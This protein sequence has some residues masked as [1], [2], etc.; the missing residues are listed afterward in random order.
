MTNHPLVQCTLEISER[1]RRLFNQLRSKSTTESYKKKPE[2]ERQHGRYREGPKKGKVQ[3]ALN[4]FPFSLSLSAEGRNQ[5]IHAGAFN[6]DQE[7]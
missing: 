3:T 5:N 7:G 6:D 2:I 1:S 4:I